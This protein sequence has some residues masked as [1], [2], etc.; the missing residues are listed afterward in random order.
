[1]ISTETEEIITDREDYYE[2]FSNTSDMLKTGNNASVVLK[3]YEEPYQSLADH[4]HLPK[5][6]EKA[7]N[8]N[9]WLRSGAYI[10]IEP[11]EAMTV[12]DVNTGKAVTGKDKEANILKINL[13]ATAEIA[14]QLRLRNLSGIIIID[15][16][17]MKDPK[18]KERVIKELSQKLAEDSITAAYVDMTKL[19]LVEVTRKKMH[20]PVHEWLK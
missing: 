13:E 3:Y 7:L 14:R 20:A 2:F 4:Y 11:T 8:K 19:G 9:V 16:I 18:H 12:I 6:I 1:M 5:D 10:V 15:Y 17:N